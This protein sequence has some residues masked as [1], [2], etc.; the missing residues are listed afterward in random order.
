[1]TNITDFIKKNQLVSFF[2]LTFVITWSFWITFGRLSKN[3][4][5]AGV[6]MVWGVFGPAL[7]GIF[8]TQITTPKRIENSRK[9]PILAFC[10]GLLVSA[11]IIIIV[12]WSPENVGELLVIG[13]IAGLPPAFVI[14]SIFSRNQGVRQYLNSLIKPRGSLFY[15]L[16]ALLIQPFSFWLGSIISAKLGQ[17]AYANP[18]PLPW[19]GWEA[20]II[21]LIIFIYQFFYGNVLGEEVGWRGFALPRLQARF[22]PLISSLIITIVWFSWH[23]PLKLMN[24]DAL[25][26][27]FYGLTFFPQ[28]VLLTWIYNRTDGSILA[29]GIAHVSTNVSGKFLFPITNGWLIVKML[30]AIILIIIDRMWEKTTSENPPGFESIDLNTICV[31]YLTG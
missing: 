6:F 22:S 8:I 4:V 20:V 28:S 3:L 30:V 27:L 2:V 17:S 7:A 31:A 12:E 15:Y 21:I 23:I 14:S 29:V 16:M 11:L 18:I 5:I 13:L 10:L 26:Y 1:L 25:P 24:P 19:N 9:A